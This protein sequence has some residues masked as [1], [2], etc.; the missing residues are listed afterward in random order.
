MKI[1]T[2][3]KIDEFFFKNPIAKGKPS[4][5]KEIANAEKRLGI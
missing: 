4:S 3:N 5:Q 1:N 2:I